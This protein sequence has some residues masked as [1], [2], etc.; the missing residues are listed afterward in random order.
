MQLT[1][2]EIIDGVYRGILSS[3]KKPKLLSLTDGSV[4]LSEATIEDTGN[5][6]FLVTVDIP[7]DVLAD[8][9]QTLC[10][11][12]PETG[13]SLDMISIVTG[14]YLDQNLAAEVSQL[15]A[16]LDML[17]ATVRKLGRTEK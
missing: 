7:S 6:T 4:T 3:S 2:L 10:I 15:R 9:V 12:D 1:K 11:T 8:G 13:E 14:Q 5:K 17:K 16:E